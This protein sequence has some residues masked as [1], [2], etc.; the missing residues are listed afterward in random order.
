MR[1]REKDDLPFPKVSE[2]VSESRQTRQS[3]GRT[4]TTQTYIV[5]MMRA[6]APGSS[7]ARGGTQRHLHAAASKAASTYSPF[8][9]SHTSNRC[10][11]CAVRGRLLHQ[12]RAYKN[13][14]LYIK[15]QKAPLEFTPH[16]LLVYFSRMCPQ[17]PAEG[18][19]APT[20]SCLSSSGCAFRTRAHAGRVDIFSVIKC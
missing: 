8:C 11:S 2:S 18:P 19:D 7:P 16:A 17:Q 6:P 13:I 3:G 12:E 15:L 14:K 4:C 5:Q 10:R 20:H 1:L 9:V